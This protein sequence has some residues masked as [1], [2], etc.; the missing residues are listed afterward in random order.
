[1]ACERE[2]LAGIRIKRR[3][4]AV[5]GAVLGK[6]FIDRFLQ[7][8]VK[9]VG[10]GRFVFDLIVRDPDGFRVFILGNGFTQRTAQQRAIDAPG[11]LARVALGS[12]F[13]RLVN[14]AYREQHQRDDKPREPGYPP[15]RSRG[16][17][18]SGIRHC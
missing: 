6:D 8:G 4:D 18:L 1:M 5:I 16:R 11:L 13:A 3:K 17:L 7:L 15:T 10:D 14:D 9:R 2:D 12:D